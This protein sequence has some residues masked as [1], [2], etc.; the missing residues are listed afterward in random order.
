M[1]S[2]AQQSSSEKP[3][4]GAPTLEPT[5]FN[6]STSKA[7]LVQACWFCGQSCN[8]PWAPPDRWDDSNHNGK[9]DAGEPYDPITTGYKDSDI[10]TQITFV[11]G[12]GSQTGFGATWYYSVDY[13]P[14]NDGNPISGGTQY[15]GWICADCLDPSVTVDPGDSL[16]VEAGAMTGPNKQGLVCLVAKDPNAS[17]DPTTNTVINS[18]YPISPRC[19]KFPLF[20]PSIGVKTYGAG[21]FVAVVK[22]MVLFI[23]NYNNSGDITGRILPVNGCECPC[24]S[25]TD[26]SDCDR[27]GVINA[28][29]NC[30][31]NFNPLQEDIDA[32]SVGDV[33]DNCPTVA[34]TSQQDSDLDGPGDACDNCPSVAN[35]DQQDSD[36]DESGDLCDNCPRDYNPTQTDTDSD[37]IGDI[38]DGCLFDPAN[39]TDGDGVCG[40]VDDC[41]SV[42]NPDQRDTDGDGI[43][44]ACDNCPSSYNP[45]QADADD[46]GKADACDNCPTVFNSSQTDSD[47]DG[48]GDACDLCPLDP[49]N[50]PDGDQVCNGIDNCPTVFNPD[51]AD[52]NHNGI[53][54]ACECRCQCHGDPACDGVISD[55]LDVVNTIN[56]AFRGAAAI[57]DPDTQCPRLPTDMNCSG[58]TDV[59]DVVKV[60]NVA[61][62]GANVATEFCEPCSALGR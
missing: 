47:H 41:P 11:L 56:V 15:V 3:A 20:N 32:D 36:G 43:G 52:T 27:D 40:A 45:T 21:K 31:R 9:Y 16:R 26:S 18:A 25:P 51:Q 2:G 46:D 42:P 23:E 58:A 4:V 19:V 29:D 24:S 37:G 28:F 38:C 22:I 59:I 5:K 34:N 7:E 1:P 61:F 44:D 55:I 10:G 33:C 12:N 6:A 39:D 60:I 49:L 35:A 17:W 30:P 57:V 8:K 62:R 54:D 50:D 48:V 14:I 53:G 13:P